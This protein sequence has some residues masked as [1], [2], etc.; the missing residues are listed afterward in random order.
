L[1]E[2]RAA[3]PPPARSELRVAF[4]FIVSYLARED[5]ATIAYLK[6]GLD[7]A[8]ETGTPVFIWLDGEY[9][10]RHGGADFLQH[11]PRRRMY[12]QEDIPRGARNLRLRSV[13][14]NQCRRQGEQQGGQ[15][16]DKGIHR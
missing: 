10:W 3:V 4:S 5:R 6:K 11:L 9:W 1:E 2:I 16:C 13:S 15:E 14:A 12:V 8:R 7:L